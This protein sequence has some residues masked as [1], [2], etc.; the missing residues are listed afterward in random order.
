MNYSHYAEKP[1]STVLL[2][3]VTER[4]YKGYADLKEV[5]YYRMTNVEHTIRNDLQSL[6][7]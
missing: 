1:I 6:L 7:F 4:G 2:K 3:R 5:T